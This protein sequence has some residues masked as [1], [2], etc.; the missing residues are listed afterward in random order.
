MSDDFVPQIIPLVRYKGND[1]D[2]DWLWSMRHYPRYGGLVKRYFF[3]ETIPS[4]V[5]NGLNDSNKILLKK[6]RSHVKR[7][8]NNIRTERTRRLL[9]RE[10]LEDIMPVD[11][12]N[13]IAGYK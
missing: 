5:R 7:F 6:V 11:L 9:M 1:I 4:D 12:I 8:Y 3:S 2:F 13:I 10:V